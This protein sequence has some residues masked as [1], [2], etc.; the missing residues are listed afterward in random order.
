MNV[1]NDWRGRAR[2]LRGQYQRC[3]GCG[4]LSAVRRLSCAR[5]GADVS[6]ATR[7][8]LPASLRAVAFS[9]SHLI[10]EAMDQTENLNAVILARLTDD[11][12]M[13]LPLCEADAALAPRLIGETLH[14]A[15]R[16]RRSNTNSREP[17]VY[18]R[19]LVAS[20]ATR[21]KLKRTE[22]KSK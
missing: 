4:A 13:A 17:I 3:D 20:A 21:S 18:E 1:V 10:V 9:H 12:F 5:C 7:S 14:I 8:A 15:L 22:V 11:Q 2:N 19:K 6:R 16:R